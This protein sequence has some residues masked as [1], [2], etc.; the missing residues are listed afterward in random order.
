MEQ[1]ILPSRNKQTLSRTPPSV[2]QFEGLRAA[3]VE[4]ERLQHN[5]LQAM[6]K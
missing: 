3:L 4:K 1:T 5:S 6:Q 2:F